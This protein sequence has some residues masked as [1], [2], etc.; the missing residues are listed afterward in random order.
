MTSTRGELESM[1]LASVLVRGVPAILE[2]KGPVR[3]LLQGQ[4]LHA[5]DAVRGLAERGEVG[6]AEVPL[7]LVQ[8]EV[9]RVAGEK[10]AGDVRAVCDAAVAVHGRDMTR[11]GR[12]E[13]ALGRLADLDVDAEQ[14]GNPPAG[15][16]RLLSVADIFAPLPP[17]PWLLQ[18]L[19]MAPGAPVLVA[20]YGFSGKTV[21]AQALA[22]AVA[23]GAD[24]WGGFSV[25]P[26]RVLHLDYEQGAYLTRSRYQRLAA[27]GGI[28]PRSLDGRL[29][30]APM[31]GWYLDGDTDDECARLAEGFDLVIVDS[32]RAACPRTD[33]NSSDARV[34]LDR[35]T[36]ISEK[37]GVTTL[38]IH[39]ARKPSQNAAGGARMS[40]RGSGALYDA[41]GSVLVFSGEKGEP[42]TVE[43]EK[44]RISGRPHDAFQLWIEDVEVAG[45]PR[46]GLRVSAL[47]TPPPASQSAS[48]R[49]QE[50]QAAVLEHVEAQGGTCGG[51]NIITKHLGARKVDV[52]DA[53][54]ELVREG[55]LSRGGTYHEP[56]FFLTG[57]DGHHE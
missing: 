34:P 13:L 40:V 10:Q 44:A 17:V 37:T 22:L 3:S 46:G 52:K 15:R 16:T 57:T 5:Y 21:M 26:G 39:H 24:T 31:P 14:A 18:A 7:D 6:P 35:L 20:G 11:P 25:R 27:A 30:L 41:C 36:R 38:V 49:L 1:V 9:R 8:A 12:A 48:Q 28:D 2:L 50:L 55:R 53:V 54:S 43:H 42:V 4:R 51:I 19:D 33:E 29:V 45:D 56:T 23:S 32:F 47:A